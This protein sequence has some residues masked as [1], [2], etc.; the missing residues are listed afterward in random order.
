MDEVYVPLYICNT[1]TLSKFIFHKGKAIYFAPLLGCWC[2][3]ALKKHFSTF[4]SC[5][6]DSYIGIACKEY[7]DPEMQTFCNIIILL[8]Q[9][10]DKNG[11]KLA[12]NPVCT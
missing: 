10:H 11:G 7:S 6:T 9:M 3:A 12:T 4:Y 1:A 2:S 8:M 5:T